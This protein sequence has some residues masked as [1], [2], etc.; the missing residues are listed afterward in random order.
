V[1]PGNEQ[2][3]AQVLKGEMGPN[4]DDRQPEPG[5]QQPWSDIV[6]DNPP[7]Q[8]PP[9]RLGVEE[10][11]KLGPTSPPPGYPGYP[12]YSPPVSRPKTN[13]AKK[14]PVQK[15]KIQDEG[16]GN[17]QAVGVKRGSIEVP[18]SG[19]E[20]PVPVSVQIHNGHKDGD[21]IKSPIPKGPATRYFTYL[22]SRGVLQKS[23]AWQSVVL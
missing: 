21:L 4:P 7:S 5:S 20:K 23:Y 9:F 22:R 8:R 13:Q 18:V 15:G 11:H 2:L 12:R 16:K 3:V 1:S 10:K 14:S 17:K 6:A 19:M